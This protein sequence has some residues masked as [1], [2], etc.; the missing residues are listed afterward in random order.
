MEEVRHKHYEYIV[1]W[2][3]GAKIQRS[4]KQYEINPVRKLEP[5]F[6][7]M[8]DLNPTWHEDDVYR[9]KPVYK[10]Q[11]VKITLLY[12]NWYIEP[13]DEGKGNCLI[14]YNAIDEQ[15][16]DISRLKE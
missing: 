7:W 1:A 16:I 14:T 8:D 6:I 5:Q 3:K 11:E 4:V 15:I 13:V 10:S 9:L 2:A 12:H